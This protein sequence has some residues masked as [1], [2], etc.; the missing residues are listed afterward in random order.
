M[1]VRSLNSPV[2]KW[3]DDVE[4]DKA[5]REWARTEAE[6]RPTLLRVGYFGSY[7]RGDWGVGS[8]LDIVAVVTESDEAFENRSLSWDLSALPLP[9]D[10]LI[11]TEKEWRQMVQQDSRFTRQLMTETTWVYPSQVG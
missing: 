9:A 3:P 2:F 6:K 7:A 10:L 11:Y 1:P 4:I 5:T 8:D